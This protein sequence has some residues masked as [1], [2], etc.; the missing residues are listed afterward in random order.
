MSNNVGIFSLVPITTN[1]FFSVDAMMFGGSTSNT[2]LFKAILANTNSYIS[3]SSSTYL[4]T[5]SFLGGIRPTYDRVGFYGSS[6]NPSTY[7]NRY[8][9]VTISGAAASLSSSNFQIDENGASIDVNYYFSPSTGNRDVSGI[10][11]TN[12][13]APNNFS[14]VYLQFNT[15]QT[16][17]ANDPIS[18]KLRWYLKRL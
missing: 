12:T 6:F 8:N 1:T 4:Y 17:L 18:M 14:V 5:P 2:N 13:S 9:G 3:S 11:L 10:A 15:G 7:P 16:I